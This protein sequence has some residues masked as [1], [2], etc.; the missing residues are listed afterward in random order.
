MI[1]VMIFRWR[2]ELDGEKHQIVASHFSVMTS[3]VVTG[4]LKLPDR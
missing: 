2:E 4:E 3:F 1:T